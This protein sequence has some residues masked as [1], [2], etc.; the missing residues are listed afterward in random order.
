ME[1]PHFSLRIFSFLCPRLTKEKKKVPVFLSPWRF[2]YRSPSGFGADLC[3]GPD[4]A[5]QGLVMQAWGSTGEIIIRKGVQWRTLLQST[6]QSHMSWEE[7]PDCTA[8]THQT[9]FIYHVT[10]LNLPVLYK[11][12]MLFTS[13][14]FSMYAVVLKRVKGWVLHFSVHLSWEDQKPNVLFYRHFPTSIHGLWLSATS[15][16][17]PAGDIKLSWD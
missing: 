3:E 11:L 2:D 13:N 7:H 10:L 16:L 4:K 8:H 12:H 1:F 6:G 5:E 15:L 17:L 9:S 14:Y